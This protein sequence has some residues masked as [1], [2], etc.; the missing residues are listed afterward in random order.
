MET[1]DGKRVRLQPDGSL[2]RVDVLYDVTAIEGGQQVQIAAGDMTT[3]R[4][5]LNRADKKFPQFDSKVAE[6]HAQTIGIQDGDK[7]KTTLEV[8][9]Q[10]T[11]GG[12]VTAIWI[13]LV[14]TTGH[15]FMDRQ[16][17][18][19]AIKAVQTHGGAFR[20][21]IDGLPGL[22]GP[23]VPLGHKIIVRTVPATGELIAYVEILGMLKVGGIFAATKEPV[24]LIEHIYAYDVL[25]RRD[26]SSEFS[27]GADEFE[28]QNWM[29]IGLGPADP[30]KLKEHFRDA[31]ET[32][33]V[34]RY[35]ERF[36]TSGSV[37]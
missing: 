7:L 6:Q 3:F 25:G 1:R 26:R 9:Y 30:E 22:N 12:I 13:Y 14:V 19:D 37:S 23:D 8:G 29:T 31:L 21:L 33:F 34:K 27:I 17:L 36:N 28:R 16:R 11:F 5:L 24:D 20:Y 2:T 10:A 18:L 32:V 4:Q 35:R 15:A